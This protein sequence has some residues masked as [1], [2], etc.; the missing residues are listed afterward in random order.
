M[1]KFMRIKKPYC[2][3][4]IRV[5]CKIKNLKMTSR[6]KDLEL[7]LKKMELQLKAAEKKIVW[8]ETEIE[9]KNVIIDTFDK[10]TH[11]HR[12]QLNVVH[13]EL[14]QTNR[15]L[16]DVLEGTSQ[17]KT[18]Q[19]PPKPPRLETNRATSST[20]VASKQLLPSTL[21]LALACKPTN[22]KS[23]FDQN[24]DFCSNI[25]Q[26]TAMDVMKSSG[27]VTFDSVVGGGGRDNNVLR[28]SSVV[29]GGKRDTS[30][31]KKMT[32]IEAMNASNSALSD[33]GNVFEQNSTPIKV[34]GGSAKPLISVGNKNATSS[35]GKGLSIVEEMK[36]R[37]SAKNPA[38]SDD[39]INCVKNS[40]PLKVSGGG[41]GAKLPPPPLGK[42]SN[43]TGSVRKWPI[44]ITTP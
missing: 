44:V 1:V 32:V 20:E 29:G 11:K 34:I 43:N 7:E 23:F 19:P 12:E 40:T 27:K 18:Q 9:L 30:S 33:D 25:K 2:I 14:L 22:A 21:A 16:N 5:V 36:N 31:E 8:L 35:A 37:L 24:I 10:T 15:L 17:P 28:Q 26:I 3:K 42:S 38:Y 6:V 39:G 13:M 41:G 4:Y